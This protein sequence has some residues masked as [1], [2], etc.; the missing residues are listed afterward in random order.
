MWVLSHPGWCKK[1]AWVVLSI[2]RRRSATSPTAASVYIWS[3][4]V[5]VESQFRLNL[6][7]LQ[8]ALQQY[9]SNASRS[10]GE[11]RICSN[12]LSTLRL[13]LMDSDGT[14]ILCSTVSTATVRSPFL[15][16]GTNGKRLANMHPPWGIAEYFL[17]ISLAGCMFLSHRGVMT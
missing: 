6:T 7:S 14:K 16:D 12:V 5:C 17:S 3:T 10:A 8:S 13:P 15:N 1:G 11:S 9:C 4:C 2:E